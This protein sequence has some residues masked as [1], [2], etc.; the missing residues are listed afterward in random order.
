MMHVKQMALLV[1]VVLGLG[2]NGLTKG[3]EAADGQNEERLELLELLEAQ[4]EIATKTRLNADYVPGIV[5]VLHGS[6]LEIRG[7]RT[8]WDALALVPGIDLS[9][10]S[11]GRRQVIVRG[12]GDVFSSGNVKLMLNGV[13]VNMARDGMFNPI[14]NIPI[15]QVERIEVM[16]GPGSAIHGEF[17]IAGVVNVMTYQ[18][19]NKVYALT[20][21]NGLRGAGVQAAW[22]SVTKNFRIGFSGSYWQ[23]DNTGTDSGT[24][25][26]YVF[27]SGS[28]SDSY[29]PG[30]VND[31][32][33]VG[34]A[35]FNLEY[36]D[37]SLLMQLNE[38]A[39]GDHFGINLTL[40]PHDELTYRTHS[41][42]VE[43]RQDIKL[44]SNLKTKLFAGWRSAGIHRDNLYLG[45]S[46]YFFSDSG[47]DIYLDDKYREEEWYGGFEWFWKP[48]IMHK[49]LLGAMYR[50]IDVPE[51]RRRINLDPDTYTPTTSLNDFSTTPAENT[52]RRISSLFAQEEFRASDAIT[53]TL[54]VSYDRYSN[55]ADSLAPR[56][57]GVWRISRANIVK[58]QYGHAFR[59]LA[60][61]EISPSGKKIKPTTIDTYDFIYIH[62]SAL[63]ESKLSLY[64]STVRDQIVYDETA[65]SYVNTSEAH[66]SGGELELTYRFA[67][68]MQLDAN[69]SY[70]HSNDSDS[71]EAVPG[72]VR[73]LADVNLV[74]PFSQSNLHIGAES[75]GEHYRHVDDPRGPQNGVTVYRLTY[76][77]NVAKDYTLRLGVKNITDERVAYP[78]PLTLDAT[79]TSVPSYRNDM[80]ES[81]RSW[82]LEL[83]YH[84]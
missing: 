58:L 5:N 56:L 68:Q 39:M 38:D 52:S 40:P 12:M 59:P 70:I 69:Y 3:A 6:E 48:G 51:S 73:W 28:E 36:K 14:M 20:G 47:I 74:V 44:N 2:L 77:Q 25:M 13:A 64:T 32:I 46:S 22:E 35:V 7:Y 37:F 9:I 24:D 82:W 66:F 30:P 29:A 76:A 33:E 11:T 71:N 43:L 72:S 55:S 42:G 63:Y 4:T 16:R 1:S 80:P 8:V 49:V 61:V 78:S 26:M 67:N 81:G 54:G 53:L 10:E 19:N 31:R 50:D 84:Y 34:A 60:M 62:K 75:T 65:V 45:P 17:A 18:E 83:Q 15:E 79:W 27:E 23:R 57:A 41:R 21:D